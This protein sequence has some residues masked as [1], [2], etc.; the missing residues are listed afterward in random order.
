M[1]VSHRFDVPC[2]E[3]VAGFQD[4]KSQV[5]DIGRAEVTQ[6]RFEGREKA[7]KCPRDQSAK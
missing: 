5:E 6:N 3:G 1:K 7:Q 4:R 2:F